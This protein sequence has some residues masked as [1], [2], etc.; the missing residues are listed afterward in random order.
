MN[1]IK[2]ISNLISW[3]IVLVVVLMAGSL[4]LSRFNTPLKFRV[5]SVLSGSMEPN[6]PVGSLVIVKPADDYH[7]DE[8]VT[9]RSE[10]TIK[11]TV[12]HRIVKVSEDPDVGSVN[13]RLKGDANEDPD[14]EMVPKQ[15]VLGKVAFHLPYLGK[16]VAFAQTQTGFVLLIVV[17]A[18]IIIYSEMM[19]I[20]KELM[21]LFSKKTKNN[22]KT[23]PKKKPEP[24]KNNEKEE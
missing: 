20:K 1:I 5:F 22:K 17:P 8:V 16:A 21:K 4:I 13:Y 12:T 14:R 19:A 10:K 18:T 6:I 2:K 23:E 24:E 7:E 9:V 15:R 11:E 3:L